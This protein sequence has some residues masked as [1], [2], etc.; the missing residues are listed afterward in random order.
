MQ[1]VERELLVVGD[2]ELLDVDL[3]EDIEGRLGLDRGDARDLVE[4]LVDVLALV[5]DAAARH[6]VALDGLVPAQRR[7]H[8]GL[9]R[10]L[11]HR[12]MLD[13]MLMPVMKSR[14]QRLLPES[15]IQPMR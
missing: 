1:Q 13:S 6:H 8:N 9:R 2:V 4:R 7:L 12:R 15:T 3:G 14:A 10:T 11:E 5:V